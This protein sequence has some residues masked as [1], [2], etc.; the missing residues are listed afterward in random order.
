MAD[1][2]FEFKLYDDG[3]PPTI[4]PIGPSTLSIQFVTTDGRSL[5]FERDTAPDPWSLV[6]ERAATKEETD[7]LTVN[8]RNAMRANARSN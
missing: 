3:R 4:V 8:R 6:E 7:R 1:T 2:M 5:T